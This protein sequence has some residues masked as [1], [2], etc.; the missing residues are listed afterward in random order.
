M[1]PDASLLYL[2]CSAAIRAI[3]VGAS[4]RS[5]MPGA[6]LDISHRLR[7]T[8]TVGRSVSLFIERGERK[9]FKHMGLVRKSCLDA[10]DYAQISA[11]QEFCNQTDN[12][13]IEYDARAGWLVQ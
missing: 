5:L 13:Q 9:E 4:L 12:I 6:S 2:K 7:S 10:V 11:L 1:S 3:T 8:T